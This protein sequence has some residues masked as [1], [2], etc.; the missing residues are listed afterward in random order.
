MIYLT[1]IRLGFLKVVFSSGGGGS[2]PPQFKQTNKQVI[3]PFNDIEAPGLHTIQY[4]NIY[5]IEGKIVTTIKTTK[6][7]YI[8]DLVHHVG[9]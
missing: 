7:I 6:T 8:K 1:L 9:R 2:I 3:Y 4:Q 5:K